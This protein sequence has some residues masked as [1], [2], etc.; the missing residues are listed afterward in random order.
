MRY[1]VDQSSL[2]NFRENVAIGSQGRNSY[3]EVLSNMG[4]S[5]TRSVVVDQ[6]THRLVQ[7][8]SEGSP[9][10][11]KSVESST[12]DE[13]IPFDYEEPTEDESDEVDL[14]K[15]QLEL[16]ATLNKKRRGL[17]MLHHVRMRPYEKRKPIILN[18][19]GQPIGPISEKEDK[20]RI[21]WVSFLDF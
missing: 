5:S 18:E 6:E 14:D 3:V 11:N 21:Q 8:E 17:T 9:S 19:F 1:Q 7:S 13:D 16:E 4:G 2:T 12:E 20:K 10:L 15:T